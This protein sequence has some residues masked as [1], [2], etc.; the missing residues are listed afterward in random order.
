MSL[1]SRLHLL[2]AFV[3]FVGEGEGRIGAFAPFAALQSFDDAAWHS[4]SPISRYI[5]L[6]VGS[7]VGTDFDPSIYMA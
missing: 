3:G 6:D 7:N 1:L 5:A 2:P 4:R